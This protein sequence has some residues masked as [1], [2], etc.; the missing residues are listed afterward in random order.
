MG[1]LIIGLIYLLICII[2]IL[3]KNKIVANQLFQALFSDTLTQKNDE[4]EQDQQD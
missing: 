3:I 2:L 4:Q 1:F